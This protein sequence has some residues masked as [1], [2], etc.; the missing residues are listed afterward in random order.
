M[1]PYGLSLPSCNRL[2]AYGVPKSF[3]QIL[4]YLSSLEPEPVKREYDLVE[5]FSGKGQLAAAFRE[6]GLKAATF[7]RDTS[8]LQDLATDNGFLDATRLVL[9]LK[10]K[11]LLW[12]GTPCS[13]WVFLSRGSTGRSRERPLGEEER[14]CVRVAN[15]LVSRVAILIYLAVSRGAVWV[16]EQPASSIMTCHPRMARIEEQCALPSANM[17]NG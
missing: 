8:P 4:E 1:R 9:G 7:E 17:L 15:L 5:L 6:R 14:E 11:G 12:C 10:H 16:L 3:F 13:S 2:F